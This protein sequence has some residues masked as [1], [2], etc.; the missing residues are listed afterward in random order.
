MSLNQ[1]LNHLPT[2]QT[3]ANQ[4][5]WDNCESGNIQ[6]L[7]PSFLGTLP[8]SRSQYMQGVIDALSL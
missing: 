5:M 2:F 8:H 6:P 7:L 3:S 4:S 1:Q